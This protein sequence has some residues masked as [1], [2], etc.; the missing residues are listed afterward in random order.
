MDVGSA[1]PS[2]TTHL[3]NGIKIIIPDNK[4]MKTFDD[5]VSTIFKKKEFNETQIQTLTQ[6]RDRLLPKLMSGELRV[7]TFNFKK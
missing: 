5:V 6:F 3:L 7:K 2:L 4:I 1:V